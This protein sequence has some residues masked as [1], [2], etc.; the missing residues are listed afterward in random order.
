MFPIIFNLIARRLT[1]DIPAI[2]A[3]N[4]YN[5]LGAEDEEQPQYHIPEVW[6]EF[7]PVNTLDTANYGVGDLLSGDLTFRLYVIEE[8]RKS[9][10]PNQIIASFLPTKIAASLQKFSGALSDL[11]DFNT[12]EQ[13]IV[14]LNTIKLVGMATDHR[15][16]NMAVTVLSFQSRAN[17]LF[18]PSAAVSVS[19]SPAVSHAFSL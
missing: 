13:D 2:K 1:T 16:A 12:S 6:V 7:A 4:W 9:P 17:L 11:P 15:F 8:I 10:N 5:A 18:I 14:A 19:A 3:I